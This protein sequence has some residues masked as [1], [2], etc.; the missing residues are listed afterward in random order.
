MFVSESSDT[1]FKR[2]WSLGAVNSVNWARVLAQIVYYFHAAFAVA[3]VSPRRG[4]RFAVPTGNFGDILAGWYAL[5]MGLP[6]RRLV[7]ATNE[8][9]ILARFFNSGLYT[10]GAVAQTLSPAMDIQVSS[11][12]ERYLYHLQVEIMH[13]DKREFRDALKQREKFLKDIIDKMKTKILAESK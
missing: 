13:T 6:I 4:L 12:F 1:A 5:R 3:R 11:N 7:L 8:N 10:R 9:D 2:A